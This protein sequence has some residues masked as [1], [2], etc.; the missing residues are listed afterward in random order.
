[1]SAIDWNWVRAFRATAE[2]GSLS[3]ASRQLGL[4][5]PTLSRQ[6]AALEEQLAVTLFERVGKRL[7]LTAG[8][9]GMLEH[10]RQMAAAAEAF[11]LTA[12]GQSSDVAGRVS[13]SVT[14]AIATHVMPDIVE[15][16]REEVPQITIV[17]TAT[18]ALSDLRRREADIAIRHV[19]PTE[20]EL[21]GRLIGELTA[22]LYASEGWIARHG[23]PRSVTDLG[24]ATLLA[25]DPVE[26]FVS[27][28]E[29]LGLT[30]GVEQCRVVSN[31]ALALW[32]MTR[33]G[34]GV[35][36]V[37]DVAAARTPGLVALLPDLRRTPV[38]LWLVTHRE[39]QTSRRIRLVYDILA[40]ELRRL[41][42]AG[43]DMNEMPGIAGKPV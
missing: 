22:H 20:P 38:P 24:G 21:I 6:V 16:L 17:V 28:M 19:R 18:D 34:L 31:S 35:G 10:A 36:V 27:H 2:T 23:V 43:A 8:G 42:V 13:L 3:A 9:A 5:Q 41:V 26:R 39:V 25:F 12:A 14:D 37:L 1:M 11:A 29:M 15:R 30:F 7:V 4:S 40:E 32:E 33:R